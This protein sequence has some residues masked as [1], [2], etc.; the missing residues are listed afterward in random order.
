MNTYTSQK[1][2]RMSFWENIEGLNR[3][4]E[5]KIKKSR[6]DNDFRTDV[7]CAFVDY[8]DNLQKEGRISESLASKV[9]LK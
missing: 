8:V 1:E 5:L 4:K 2:V 3:S 7:R 9:T 6:P